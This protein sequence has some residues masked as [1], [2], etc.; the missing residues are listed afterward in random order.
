MSNQ[1]NFGQSIGLRA[2]Q[3]SELARAYGTP[4]TFFSKKRRARSVNSSETPRFR[5]NLR[6]STRSTKAPAAVS[7]TW[8][9][10]SKSARMRRLLLLPEFLWTSL[11][12]WLL[13][14]TGSIHVSVSPC[15]AN[16]SGWCRS[17]QRI[18]RSQRHYHAERKRYAARVQQYR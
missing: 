12:A 5:N 2:S 7:R 9:H 14:K 17:T 3:V 18:E 1:N 16:H 6:I 15:I 13:R 4:L 10:F 8:Q 11:A